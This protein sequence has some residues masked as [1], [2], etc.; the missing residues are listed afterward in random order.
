MN[1]FNKF[2]EFVEQGTTGIRGKRLDYRYL[3]IIQNQIKLFKDSSI[4]DLASHDGRWSL[5]ALEAGA[6]HV[7]AI[8]AR[9][10]LASKSKILLKKY[11]YGIEKF[12][13]LAGDLIEIISTLDKR[14]FDIVL[15]LGFFYHTMHHFKLL[16]EINRLNPKLLIIDTQLIPNIKPNILLRFDNSERDGASIKTEPQ[17]NKAIVGIPS[18]GSLKMMLEHLKFNGEFLNWKNF[19]KPNWDGVEDYRDSKRFTIVVRPNSS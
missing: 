19:S 9:K 12:K 8:E 13:V 2:P 7:T 5:A 1:F 18:V 16:S 3:A 10:H 11:G 15:C 14:K 4:L 17:T 6:K